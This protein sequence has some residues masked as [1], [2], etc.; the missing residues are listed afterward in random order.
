MIVFI[1]RYEDLCQE[2]D[3]VSVW[4]VGTVIDNI[5]IVLLK[6]LLQNLYGYGHLIQRLE[7]KRAK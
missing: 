2:I 6:S 3:I 4:R 5:S 7:N 1:Y